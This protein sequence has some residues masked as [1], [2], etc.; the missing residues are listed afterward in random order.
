MFATL[1]RGLQLK[2]VSS[3]SKRALIRCKLRVLQRNLARLQNFYF[4][5]TAMPSVN[6]H[7]NKTNACCSPKL[8]L[9]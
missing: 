5:Q 3:N 6:R 2:P 7:K 9:F 8:P 4:Q 1:P